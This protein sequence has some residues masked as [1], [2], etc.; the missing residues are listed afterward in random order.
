[1]SPLMYVI[2]L[3][4]GAVLIYSAVKGQ[5]PRELI[6]SALGKGSK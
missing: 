1:M 5:D 2:L 3:I 4:V 6:K